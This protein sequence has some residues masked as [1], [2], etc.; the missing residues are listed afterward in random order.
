MDVL[1]NKFTSDLINGVWIPNDPFTHPN[2]TIT[3]DVITMYE[4]LTFRGSCVQL[5]KDYSKRVVLE[6]FNEYVN[7]FLY[8]NAI[9]YLNL[10]LYYNAEAL[11][12]ADKYQ[13]L[14]E[15]FLSEERDLQDYIID[16]QELRD[17]LINIIREYIINTL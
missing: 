5:I 14:I 6:K 12:I 16:T 8:K 4:I 1:F 10:Y 3:F 2:F 17:E 13:L 15:E 7:K 9:T 11:N